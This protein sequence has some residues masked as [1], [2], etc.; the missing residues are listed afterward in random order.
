M[1][2]ADDLSE[3]FTQSPLK[4]AVRGSARFQSEFDDFEYCTSPSID[5]NCASLSRS[6]PPLRALRLMV[7]D[8]TAA[9][10]A[11]TK[12]PP[13]RREFASSNLFWA[14][15]NSLRWLGKSFEAAR[16]L[17]A[18]RASAMAAWAAP[19]GL[20]FWWLQYH[21]PAPPRIRRRRMRPI[22]LS[23]SIEI[24]YQ[25]MSAPATFF[26]LAIATGRDFIARI[27]AGR[28]G[29]GTLPRFLGWAHAVRSCR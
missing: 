15:S 20:A 22:C 8:S 28:T 7:C 10:C 1:S 14:R 27:C 16:E 5:R 21:Q 12:R 13:P 26:F 3:V 24:R 2:S 18:S 19:R 25:S 11:S 17:R 29:I 6:P 4:S 9:L 23:R